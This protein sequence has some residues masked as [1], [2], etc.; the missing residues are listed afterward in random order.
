MF[1]IKKKFY[2]AT[3]FRYLYNSY[4]QHAAKPEG[5]FRNKRRGSKIRSSDQDLKLLP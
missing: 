5:R 4:C 2:K 1:L 3:P